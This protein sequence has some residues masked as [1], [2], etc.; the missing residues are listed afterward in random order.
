MWLWLCVTCEGCGLRW[1][2]AQLASALGVGGGFA[3]AHRF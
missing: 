1:A 2:G 3:E